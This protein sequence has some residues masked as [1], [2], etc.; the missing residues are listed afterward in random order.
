MI[1]LP[2]SHSCPPETRPVADCLDSTGLDDAGQYDRGSCPSFSETEIKD[3]RS[4]KARETRE[5]S[6][7][8]YAMIWA[9]KL[10]D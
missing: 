5:R 1:N 9:D 4:G 8:L 10:E 7:I 2:Y 3:Q 6:E